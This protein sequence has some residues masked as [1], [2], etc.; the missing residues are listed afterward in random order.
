[1]CVCVC[2]CVHTNLVY[3]DIHEIYIEST[4]VCPLVLC[5]L[6][7]M[8]REEYRLRV[9]ENRARRKIFEPKPEEITGNWRKLHTKEVYRL[10]TSPPNIIWGSNYV[11]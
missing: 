3:I 2:V 4:T 1:M 6:S 5:G 10:G 8:L 11:G 9:F 7:L